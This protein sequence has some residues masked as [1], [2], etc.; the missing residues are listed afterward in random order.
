MTPQER[1][2]VAR[3]LARLA[4]HELPDDIHPDN[5]DVQIIDLGNLDA[6]GA[7]V[8]VEATSSLIHEAWDDAADS[9]T[10]LGGITWHLAKLAPES[11][12]GAVLLSAQHDIIE[13]CRAHMRIGVALGFASPKEASNYEA[14]L[15][16][17]AVKVAELL[18][19]AG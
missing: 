16:G 1:L 5:V 4:G 7:N 11:K 9:L 3:H 2:E 6:E 10:T 14:K 8:L 18:A 12:G 17:I 15:A 13:A 19:R